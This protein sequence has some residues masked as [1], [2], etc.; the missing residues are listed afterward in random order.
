MEKVRT[1]LKYIEENKVNDY[2]NKINKVNDNLKIY[3]I[4]YDE[5]KKELY[6]LANKKVLL[7]QKINKI[8]TPFKNTNELKLQINKIYNQNID[9]EQFISLESIKNYYCSILDNLYKQKY[10][11]EDNIENKLKPKYGNNV[12][13]VIYNYNLD[14]I[15][16]G[17]TKN[18]NRKYKHITFKLV[19]NDISIINSETK[20]A[21]SILEILQN[22]LK[23]LY[24]IYKRFNYLD[25]QGCYQIRS[26]NANIYIDITLYSI[27]IY[28]NNN[29][30]N[31]K[32]NTYD[33]KYYIFCDEKLEEFIKNISSDLTNFLYVPISDC[34][35]W[36]QDELNKIRKLQLNN[37]LL[38]KS[39][40]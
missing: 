33:D 27:K 32:Y 20:E 1:T 36:S 9:D 5:S 39:I 31:I 14:T 37:P 26:I 35:K 11:I 34:P 3:E 12:G 4:K 24:K 7:H 28:C 2:I 18:Y 19:D 10:E 15:E 6:I 40:G 22:E 21:K 8:L 38:K 13:L 23:E 25:K 29:F 30:F 17:F 16:I